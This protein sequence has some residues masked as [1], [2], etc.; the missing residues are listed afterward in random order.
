MATYKTVGG[1]APQYMGPEAALAQQKL[2]RMLIEGG[3]QEQPMRH[4]TQALGSVLQT[5]VGALNQDMGIRDIKEGQAAGN[6][7][8]GRMLMG[9]DASAA[10]ANPYSADKAMDY[11]AK[12][13]SA[14]LAQQRAEALQ[15]MKLEAQRNDPLYQARLGKVRA[16]TDKIKNEG[17]VDAQRIGQLTRMG[18]DPN[19][20]EGLAYIA[21]G[22]LPNAAVQQML[23]RQQRQQTAPKITEGLTNLLRMTNDYDDASFSNAVGPI[24]GSTPDSLLSAAPAN[25]ARAWGEMANVVEGGNANPSEVRSNIQGS[26]EALAAAIKPLIR[27]PGEGVWT[28]ADQA[29]LVQI[30][31]DLAQARDKPEFKRRLNAVRDRIKSNFDLD[32]GFEALGQTPAQMLQGRGQKPF[33]DS[34]DGFKV[35]FD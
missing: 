24:Q 8:L 20:A 15:R 19:S 10:M 35:E 34:G 22:K 3:M 28:D 1:V 32:I 13:R 21:N 31:G 26:T 9:E 17:T 27:G 18:I 2:G 29:R 6:Q 12:E 23:A 33:L 7:A 25:I 14:T 16:E 4:W 11:Q 5:G 30:V